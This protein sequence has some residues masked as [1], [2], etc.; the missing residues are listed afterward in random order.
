MPSSSGGRA[1]NAKGCMSQRL[2]TRATVSPAPLCS[3]WHIRNLKQVYPDRRN[4]ARCGVTVLEVSQSWGLTLQ[5]GATDPDPTRWL[6]MRIRISR[7]REAPIREQ[8]V[9]QLQFFI[10]NLWGEPGF[11]GC[12][13]TDRMADPR[14]RCNGFRTF[15]TFDSPFTAAPTSECC[16][17]MA[18]RR[19]QRALWQHPSRA[20]PRQPDFPL[21]SQVTYYPSG[22]GSA[23]IRPS[24][25]PNSLP[26]RCPS[27]SSSQ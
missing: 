16:P 11:F 8:L 4:L 13:G 24:M 20:L 1:P 12:P 7:E 21:P 18:F 3:G 23:Q 2:R 5:P 26:F 22:T 9:A 15:A 27:A 25:S 14:L 17:I 19:R 6:G 10:A